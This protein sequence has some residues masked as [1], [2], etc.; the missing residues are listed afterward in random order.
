M[1]GKMRCLDGIWRHH[2]ARHA[3]TH[4]GAL[5]SG[6]VRLKHSVRTLL[7]SDTVKFVRVNKSDHDGHIVCIPLVGNYDSESDHP[8]RSTLLCEVG[9]A[10]GQ[11]QMV[12][13]TLA[14]DTSYVEIDE[15]F[16]EITIE[17]RTG[18][19]VEET[20]RPHNSPEVISIPVVTR[21]NLVVSG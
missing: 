14:L 9:H 16:V 5:V 12:N 17:A 21:N 7:F 1:D 18:G 6:T 8:G 3:L 11:G 10:I 19:E 2:N 20:G 15:G 4:M 13:F